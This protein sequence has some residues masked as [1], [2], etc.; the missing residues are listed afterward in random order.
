[1]CAS[2]QRERRSNAS[3]GDAPMR[4]LLRISK[5]YYGKR[6]RAIGLRHHGPTYF[7]LDSYGTPIFFMPNA[8]SPSSLLAPCSRVC[9]GDVSANAGRASCDNI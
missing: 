3:A 5:K 2:T 8:L 4:E 9:E 7:F 1:M 6:H